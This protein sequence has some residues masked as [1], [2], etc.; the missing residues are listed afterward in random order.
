MLF[1]TT[2]TTAKLRVNKLTLEQQSLLTPFTIE[3]SHLLTLPKSL[4][5]QAKLTTQQMINHG[6]RVGMNGFDDSE[7]KKEITGLVNKMILNKD[8]LTVDPKIILPSR[9][10]NEDDLALALF[11]E[12]LVWMDAIKEGKDGIFG[13]IYR[14]KKRTAYFSNIAYQYML[15][16]NALAR[17]ELREKLSEEYIKPTPQDSVTDADTCE[18]CEDTWMYNCGDICEECGKENGEVCPECGVC[19]DCNPC[20]EC[21]GLFRQINYQWS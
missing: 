12:T 4:I 9:T 11:I 1:D 14:F 5:K 19:K 13:K 8:F 7:I 16:D 20:Y 2:S 6:S 3:I 21:Q 17:V 15:F 10:T 18:D